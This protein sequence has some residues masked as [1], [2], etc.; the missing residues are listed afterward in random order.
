M[1]YI[2]ISNR[3]SKMTCPNYL[4]LPYQAGQQDVGP[5]DLGHTTN[6]LR[7]ASYTVKPPQYVARVCI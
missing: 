4:H 1:G 2:V 7:Q 3:V 6:E 5:A